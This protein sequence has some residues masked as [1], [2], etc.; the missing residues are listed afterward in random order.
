MVLKKCGFTSLW[1][2]RWSAG[3]NQ[4]TPFS[5]TL[6]FGNWLNTVD[7]IF[8]RAILSYRISC[9]S[10]KN[11]KKREKTPCIFLPN[12]IKKQNRQ[13]QK[14]V[15]IIFICK[16][17]YDL[18]VQCAGRWN[19]TLLV[20]TYEDRGT[21]II[22]TNIRCEARNTGG[23]WLAFQEQRP[24]F[25]ALAPPS[26]SPDAR[27]IFKKYYNLT[28]EEGRSELWEKEETQ[29]NVFSYISPFHRCHFPLAPSCS[30]PVSQSLFHSAL[31]KK[32]GTPALWRRQR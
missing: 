4:I 8:R 6:I 17:N 30:L 15:K 27:A 1:L 11:C 20:L 5:Y 21:I 19:K 31:W 12:K 7:E 26:Q 28:S 2:E 18:F 32:E 13:K 25:R 14:A 29:R 10:R 24:K 22:D 3:T 16:K 9:W 23:I